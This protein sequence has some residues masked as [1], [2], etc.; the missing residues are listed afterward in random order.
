MDVDMLGRNVIEN[1][2]GVCYTGTDARY[3]NLPIE[4]IQSL[5]LQKDISDS[6]FMK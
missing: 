6:S 3:V 4:D 1:L 5:A 2:R